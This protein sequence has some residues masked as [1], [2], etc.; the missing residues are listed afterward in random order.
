MTTLYD[1]GYNGLTTGPQVH[2][3]GERDL[4]VVLANLNGKPVQHPTSSYEEILFP[5]IFAF[6][7]TGPYY[8]GNVKDYY[9]VNSCGRF[10]WRHAKTVG[11]IDLS[12]ELSEMDLGAR[13][14][15]IVDIV[16]DS[17]LFNFTDYNY[18]WGNSDPS[19]REIGVLI[20]DSGDSSIGQTDDT[21]KRISVVSG[22]TSLT[23]SA[24]EL[25]HQLG[26]IDL[27]G[28][29]NLNSQLTLTGPHEGKDGG[30]QA[31]HLDPWH[32]M[33]FGWCEPRL[34]Q[35]T[36]DVM[37]LRLTAPGAQDPAGAVILYDQGRGTNEYFILEF[38][39]PRQSAGR[40]DGAGVA[41]SGY[42][43]NASTTGIAIWHVQTDNAFN[44]IEHAPLGPDGQPKKYNC[45]F[46]DAD[47]GGSLDPILDQP[48]PDFQ[49]GGT[50]LWSARKVTPPLRWLDGS[51]TG[52]KLAVLDYAVD[53][54][55]A[56]VVILD[57]A[58]DIDSARLWPSSHSSQ[59][60]IVSTWGLRG[61]FELLALIGGSLMHCWRENDLLSPLWHGPF[62]ASASDSAQPP[63]DPTGMV[64][65]VA[66]VAKVPVAVSLIQSNYG[67]P[68][69]LEAVIRVHPAVGKD[70]LE[71]KVRGAGGWHASRAIRVDNRLLD[72]VTGN[73]AFIQSD[74]GHK[75]NFELLVAVGTELRHYY[76]DNDH[77]NLPWQG[78]ILVHDWSYTA[79]VNIDRAQLARWPTHVSLIQ[80]RPGFGS[81]VAVVLVEAME[82]ANTLVLFE[83]DSNGW[84]GPWPIFAEGGQ[85]Q[86]LTGNPAL[87]QS[88]YG[89]NGNF[90]L[91]VP[92]GQQ[93]HHYWRDN[94]APKP[95][96]HGPLVA[97]D[98][99]GINL[100]LFRTFA[101]TP[102]SVALVQ[103]SL[104]PLGDL[105]AIVRV[106]PHVGNDYLL[107]L[108]RGS[109]GWHRAPLVAD[110]TRLDEVSGF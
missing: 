18:P 46:V 106:R 35:L 43:A 41:S 87:I 31:W 40:G 54:D 14:P 64:A 80:S 65:P 94:D 108:V 34:H 1:F 9:S 92:V 49:I 12:P 85:I 69:N 75:G 22:I 55:I 4:L 91:L 50:R 8:P 66:P 73:P 42:D 78:P 100:E 88:G 26:S 95:K 2:A 48:Y 16:R 60:L 96:W 39:N 29:R 47:P 44:P 24:H 11:P 89:E 86:G 33:R 23:L 101:E 82:G 51:S 7:N 19:K 103:N 5:S 30:T 53:A 109:K 81:F 99:G 110:G 74:F 20:I 68:G 38:R 13:R 56:E 70:W 71:H 62:P 97:A 21:Y 61:N 90:E 3:A 57:E 105:E 83:M 36:P 59:N 76:R 102:L 77:P 17:G 93:V 6:N 45:I 98:L 63:A 52:I 58:V 107:T 10:T 27:Y 28:Y 67:S 15:A 25:A 79:G 72:G 104:H 37:P 32:K 84:H